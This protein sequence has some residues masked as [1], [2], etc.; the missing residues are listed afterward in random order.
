MPRAVR[1]KPSQAPSMSGGLLE[2]AGVFYCRRRF[3]FCISNAIMNI[4]STLWNKIFHSSTPST[5]AKS[6][7]EAHFVPTPLGTSQPQRA[8]AI[9]LLTEKAKHAG[10][11]LNWRESIVDLMKLVGMDSSLENR[12]ALAKELDYPGAFSDTAKMN[13]WLQEKVMDRLT[14][15]GGQTPLQF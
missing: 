13:V 6:S 5:Q 10:Q 7:E 15:N 3:R 2:R 1:F 11:K 4:F 14:R 9:A 8:D 12:I